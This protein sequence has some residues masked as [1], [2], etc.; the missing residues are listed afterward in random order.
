MN[1]IE[2][3]LHIK[4]LLDNRLGLDNATMLE[5]QLD[6]FQKALNKYKNHKGLRFVFIHGEGSGKLK[7]KI[8]SVLKK[9]YKQY[10]FIDASTI[11]S[12]KY[13]ISTAIVVTIK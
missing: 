8:V 7:S 10:N 11:N 3:D 4:S 9:S 1:I 2:V 5:Y 13:R 6:V 12:F